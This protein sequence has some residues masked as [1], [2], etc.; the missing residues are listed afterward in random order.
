M[1][2]PTRFEGTIGRTV[3]ASTPY[4]DEPPHPGED[5]PNV[6]VVLLD[7][8]GFGQF[9]C[10]GSDIDTPNIDALA[11]NG[12]QF[13]NF[14]VTPLCSPTRAAL[15]TGRSQHAVGMRSISNFR[16]GFPHMLGHISNH[17]ATM[18]E[19]LRYQGYAT[20]A[21]GKWHL[22][23]MEQ[24]S[25]AGP[26]D[27]W[28]LGRG[29]DR[30]YGFLDGETDQFHP[31]LVCDNHPIDP[32]GTP[33]TGY[34]LSEDL[35]DQALKMISDTT[36]VR[37]DR[38]FFTYL[39]F[40]ATHAPHQ[41][42]PEYMAKYRGRFDE[43]WDVV[44]ERW[45]NRQLELG[46]IPPGTQLAPR[47][48]GVEPW[49][50]LP[51]N[52]QRLACRLQE[53]FAAFLDHTD[54]QIG[55]LIA[56]LRHLGQLDNT[57]VIVHTDNGASQEG[58]PFGVMHEMKFFNAILETPD[59]AI[60]RIDDIG[61]PHSHT[62]YPWGWAQCG[63]TPFKWYKQNTHE[64]GVHVPMI[65]HWPA[66]IEIAQRGTKRDQFVFVAD[67]APTIYDLLGT[68]VPAVYRGLEQLPVTG[69]SFAA[70]L[71]DSSAP[72]TNTLQYFENGG[73]RALVAGDWKAVCKHAIGADFDTEPWELYH[74]AVDRSEYND[75]AASHPDKLAEVIDLWW[76]EAE[77][78]GVLPLDDRGFELFG[79]RFRPRSP[80]PVSRRYV[81]RP[82]MS[83][84]TSQASAAI[85][86]RSFD[87]TARITRGA[88]DEGVL[89]ATGTQNSGIA[90]FVQND[91]LVVDYNAFDD[92][93]VVESSFV[94]PEGDSE[95]V[96]RFVRGEKRRGAVSL[97]VNGEPAG[98]VAIALFMRMI[99]SVGSSIGYNHGSSVS[100]R[101][102]APFA[103]TGTLHEVVIELAAAREKDAQEAEARAGM[104]R[105]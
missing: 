65:L 34:H 2:R 25:A 89:F 83:P 38:P 90:V 63:N 87:L 62:N 41:A 96:V 9:G 103:F 57:I 20:F 45:F 42:P 48:P 101:Y 11:A 36:G 104:A 53:A 71:N 10:F 32:P 23:P 97:E 21:V 95:L 92:H 26:F 85:G 13:T 102:R 64:G 50:S 70:V 29:F 46:V 33:E 69:H 16:T 1:T 22:A 5:A 61:G 59:Q 84:M 24:C 27:Q 80:H 12:L 37:P 99:S 91:R 15:L 51:E 88:G 76:Q 72:A 7:D 44:R 75:L 54:A 28:P 40:G 19:V 79:A 4:F 3:T 30:F 105:Q 68:A 66:H 55:R 35:V 93:S 52:Q 86:G 60:T 56:G 6:V 31:E 81:Y 74:L 17:A 82:P 67:I 14:H 39:A 78:H 8:A 47:N 58:G 73:S 77:R 100:P 18:A 94:V 43:G 98:A 49:D